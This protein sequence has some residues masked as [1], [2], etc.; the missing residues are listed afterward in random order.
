MQRLIPRFETLEDRWTPACDVYTSADGAYLYIIG[1]DTAN[2][3]QIDQNDND[4]TI[5]VHCDG[6]NALHH[7]QLSGNFIYVDLKGGNDTIY[8]RQKSSFVGWDKNVTIK[9]GQGSL[10]SAYIDFGG[11][12]GTRRITRLLASQR[13]RRFRQ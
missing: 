5:K 11:P 7:G 1:D 4:N 9:L 3:V 8:W 6:D 2:E 10:N 12:T 13:R